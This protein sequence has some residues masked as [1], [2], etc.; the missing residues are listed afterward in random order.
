LNIAIRTMLVQ[1]GRAF[2]QV[3]G[4]IVA[5]KE[6]EEFLWTPAV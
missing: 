2:V 1:N 5:E 4:G 3:G 6:Y